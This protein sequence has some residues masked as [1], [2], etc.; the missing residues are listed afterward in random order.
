M[1][2][3]TSLVIILWIC[4][5]MAHP[6]LALEDT[7][8]AV[9]N[10]D[11]ITQRDLTDYQEAIYFQLKSE[12]KSKDQID[13]IM[14]GLQKDSIKN[15]IDD[16]IMLSEANRIGLEIRKE[17]VDNRL[18][19]IQKQ[20]PSEQAFL[21][22]LLSQGESI[23]DLQKKITDQ[24]KIKFLIE[25]DV[26]SKIFVNPQEVTDYYK[27]NFENYRKPE[28]VDLDSIYIPFSNDKE[29]ARARTSEARDLLKQGKDFL[30]VAKQYSQSPSIGILSKNE[31]L[32]TIEEAVMGLKEGEASPPIEVTNG[33]YIFKLKAKLPEEVATL[34]EVKD[35]IYN[36]L[37]SKKYKQQF[38]T[39]LNKLKKDAYIDIKS[40]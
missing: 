11:I 34:A 12:G 20:Y 1:P 19:E 32:P 35:K 5:C 27:A 22:A 30:E 10:S 29:K 37:F 24:L 7:I 40:Q 21:A 3:L 8:I 14:A 4:F 33:I 23:S 38:L 17:L 39:W 16:K 2:R 18:A 28:R 26:R 15:L 13:Q 36:E 6:A 31:M 25:E 9:V